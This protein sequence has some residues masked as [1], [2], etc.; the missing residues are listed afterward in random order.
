MAIF[1]QV[2]TPHPSDCVSSKCSEDDERER[3]E[4]C[5]DGKHVDYNIGA[6][7]KDE[8]VSGGREYLY[9]NISRGL[10]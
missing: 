8:V 6:G 5:E 3:A 4:G 10:N 7:L 9:C 1:F 2:Q